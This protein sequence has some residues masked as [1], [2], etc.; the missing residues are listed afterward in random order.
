[1]KKFTKIL[2]LALAIMTLTLALF[3]CGG[4]SEGDGT[5]T[6]EV[7]VVVEVSSETYRAYV[8]KL[9]ELESTDE[10]FLSVI[11]YLSSRAGEALEVTVDDDRNVTRIGG[12][13]A[14]TGERL[15]TY[16]TELSD[17]ILGSGSVD[18]LIYNEREL[19]ESR[20]AIYEMSAS[21]GAVILFRLENK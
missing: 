14:G 11:R 17:V 9:E 3:S 21:D 20:K 12:L 18:P 8:A 15:V 16:T 10:G 2:S 7:T 6:G 1:M 19:W 13:V 4:G 5:V